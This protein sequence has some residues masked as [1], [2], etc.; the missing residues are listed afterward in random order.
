MLILREHWL[1]G[2][3]RLLF[4]VVTGKDKSMLS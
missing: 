1:G 3:S 2:I 4:V